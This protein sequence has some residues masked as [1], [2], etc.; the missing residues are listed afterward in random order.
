MAGAALLLVPLVAAFLALSTGQQQPGGSLRMENDGNLHIDAAQG[1]ITTESPFILN[2]EDVAAT[3]RD[4]KQQLEA[5]KTSSTSG[6]WCGLNAKNKGSYASLFTGGSATTIPIVL[7]EGHDPSVSCP[8]GYMKFS[9][10][11]TANHAD[12]LSDPTWTCIKT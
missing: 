7:C 3:L 6:S 10:S 2:G 11:V 1:N 5:L 8:D 4:L 12:S 9:F